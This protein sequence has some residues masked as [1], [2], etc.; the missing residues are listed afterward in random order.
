MT[1]EEF[2][3]SC[4]FGFVLHEGGWWKACVKCTIGPWYNRRVITCDNWN[5]F[6]ELMFDCIGGCKLKIIGLLY[7]HTA[8]CPICDTFAVHYL[9]HMSFDNIKLYEEEHYDISNNT[10]YFNAEKKFTVD[11]FKEYIIKQYN[12]FIKDNKLVIENYELYK[13]K[14]AVFRRCK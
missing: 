13:Q 14:G 5:K 8:E 2:I 10:K 9:H 3:E 7:F 12:S 4:T 6:S 1:I 11:E